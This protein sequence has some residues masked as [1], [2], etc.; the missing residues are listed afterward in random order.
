MTETS[1]LDKVR[2]ISKSCHFDWELLMYGKTFSEE[3]IGTFV[4]FVRSFTQ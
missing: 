4:E 2:V 1:M 3:V